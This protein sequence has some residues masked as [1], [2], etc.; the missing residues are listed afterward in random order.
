MFNPS[1][2]VE[3]VKAVI[4][5][6]RTAVFSHKTGDIRDDIANHLERMLNPRIVS[7]AL[8]REGDVW[9]V[10]VGGCRRVGY[11]ADSSPLP[12]II[13]D[14]IGNGTI[15]EST[16]MSDAEIDRLISLIYSTNDIE[17]PGNAPL[18]GSKWS[19]GMALDRAV[20]VGTVVKD[21]DGDVGWKAFEGD[22]TGDAFYPDCGGKGLGHT[23]TILYLG[24]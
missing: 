24:E 16:W 9:L 13:Y 2:D 12:W 8:A 20:P 21:E 23:W 15:I 10:E 4:Q 3:T 7:P 19:D 1:Y 17:I 22:W 6:I 18:V 14:E 5:E 11:K